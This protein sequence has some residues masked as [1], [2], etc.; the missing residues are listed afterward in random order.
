MIEDFLARPDLLSLLIFTPL[1]GAV[2]LL[3]ASRR[4]A[5]GQRHPLH[6]AGR[7]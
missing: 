3:F 6:G 5:R 4:R 7:C 2:V 1:I